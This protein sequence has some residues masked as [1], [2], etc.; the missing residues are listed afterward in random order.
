ML[1]P[2]K[3]VCM[4]YLLQM[5]LMLLHRPFGVRYENV[6]PGFDFIGGGLSAGGVLG[7]G[8]VASSLVSLRPFFPPCLWPSLA[9][10]S[11]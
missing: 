2:L 6:I 10:C 4:P 1:L 7:I 5:F 8:T 3:W 9:T 11:E